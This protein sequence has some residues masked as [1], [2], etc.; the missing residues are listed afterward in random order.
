MPPN[1]QITL[2]LRLALPKSWFCGC[3][4][5]T[6]YARDCAA[7]EQR[8]FAA[9]ANPP[10]TPLQQDG[11]IQKVYGGGGG[12]GCGDGGGLGVGRVRRWRAKEGVRRSQT[13]SAGLTFISVGGSAAECI[14]KDSAAQ[15]CRSCSCNEGSSLFT[16][17]PVVAGLEAPGRLPHLQ[18][19]P[20]SHRRYHN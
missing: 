12:G 18:L 19:P 5:D 15:S 20:Q 6:V 2:P 10:I 8:G 4:V 13:F 11:G 7:G 14:L 9:A 16:I 1:L 17:P 3:S